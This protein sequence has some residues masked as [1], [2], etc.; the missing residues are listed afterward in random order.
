MW[1][2]SNALDGQFL[3][4][5]SC[6]LAAAA[7]RLGRPDFLD[8]LYSSYGRSLFFKRTVERC[9]RACSD[10]APFEHVVSQHDHEPLE[11]EL[12]RLDRQF[13]D[14]VTI[15]ASV[16]RLL[17]VSAASSAVSKK[18]S[19]MRTTVRAA[20][21]DF[22]CFSEVYVDTPALFNT[23]SQHAADS[24]H[25]HIL[26]HMLDKL[27]DHEE[28]VKAAKGILFAGHNVCLPAVSILQPLWEWLRAHEIDPHSLK[29]G[30]TDRMTRIGTP[31][32][33]HLVSDWIFSCS[34]FGTTNA[35][36]ASARAARALEAVCFAALQ[37]T[38]S[39]EISLGELFCKGWSKLAISMNFIASEKKN[40]SER[41]AS[42][43][44]LWQ[45]SASAFATGL[46]R[47]IRTLVADAGVNPLEQHSIDRV[48]LGEQL[49][50]TGTGCITDYM[51]L[52]GE[53][54][55]PAVQWLAESGGV[56]RLVLTQMREQHQDGEAERA[57]KLSEHFSN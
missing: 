20:A 4:G 40:A 7:I 35:D 17:E 39:D 12:I 3:R 38:S 30:E 19:K 11:D 34:A 49:G 57:K 52:A 6:N 15:G 27:T 55:A 24:G 25:W 32:F 45:V 16:E 47:V 56:D 37:P 13:T 21:C 14:L 8:W 53:V 2:G 36:H 29:Q 9:L 33:E 5:I 44:Q 46:A 43:Q 51:L 1:F 26:R 18:L 23:L 48:F 50:M 54:G 10:P 42:Q 41:G 28:R 31:L 22:S